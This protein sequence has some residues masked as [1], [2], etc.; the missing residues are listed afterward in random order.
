MNLRS[1]R[2]LQITLKLTH[3]AVNDKIKLGTGI[4]YRH[5]PGGKRRRRGNH[6]RLGGREQV[7]QEKVS[8][9]LRAQEN[10]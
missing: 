6:M 4:H 5:H 7:D 2:S 3:D 10:E 8:G 1:L 9:R